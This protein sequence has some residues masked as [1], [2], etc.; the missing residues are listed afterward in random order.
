V[1]IHAGVPIVNLAFEN[2][3]LQPPRM[4]GFFCIPAARSSGLRPTCWPR[5]GGRVLDT[6]GLAMSDV[7]RCTV[8]LADMMEW[9]KFNQIYRALLNPPY[10]ARS[11][12]GVN[13]LALGARVELECVAYSPRQKG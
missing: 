8:Y 1:T 2:L 10:P 13:G 5:R 6:Y 4:M 9:G 3:T 11:A 12:V 7:I